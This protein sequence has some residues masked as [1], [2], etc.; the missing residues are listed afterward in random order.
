VD[1]LLRNKK[2]IA[3]HIFRWP[4]QKGSIIKAPKNAYRYPLQL[5]L[6]RFTDVDADVN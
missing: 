6:T 5:H 2:I 3:A 4:T 1:E